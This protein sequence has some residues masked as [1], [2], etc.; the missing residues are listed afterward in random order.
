MAGPD[1]DAVL[2]DKG[3]GQGADVIA[4]VEAAAAVQGDGVGE[5]V[6]ADL[7][8]KGH[9]H[10][11]LLAG[12]ADKADHVAVGLVERVEVGDALAAGRAPGGPELEDMD[13]LAHVEALALHKLEVVGFP[14]GRL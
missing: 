4:L 11:A 14:V 12:D 5:I 9:D 2:D 1:N 7:G 10:L 3:R 6:L 13:A 8:D